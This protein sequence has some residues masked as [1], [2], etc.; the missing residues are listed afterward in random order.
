[1]F[2]ML[3][4]VFGGWTVKYV[5]E[6]WLPFIVHHGISIP[7]VAAI[8]AGLFFGEVS[9]PLAIITWLIKLCGVI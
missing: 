5:L 2:L 6:T 7:W 1:L 9:V 4:V 3:N 8:I